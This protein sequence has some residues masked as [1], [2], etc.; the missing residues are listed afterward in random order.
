[1]VKYQPDYLLTGL[2]ASQSPQ[3][4]CYLALRHQNFTDHFMVSCLA[5]DLKII[6]SASQ[7]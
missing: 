4:Q 7:L 2:L 1:M 6:L 3:L 5:V